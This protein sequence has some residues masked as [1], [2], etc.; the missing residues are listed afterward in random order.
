MALDR[1]LDRLARETPPIV[2]EGANENRLTK[3]IENCDLLSEYVEDYK[4]AATIQELEAQ[5]HQAEMVGAD[6]IEV[7]PKIFAHYCGPDTGKNAN[8]KSKYFHFKGVK[9][10]LAGNYAAAKKESTMTMEQKLFGAKS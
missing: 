4:P 2:D 1:E 6:S 3:T 7:T 8:W 5:M 9:A 10:Y